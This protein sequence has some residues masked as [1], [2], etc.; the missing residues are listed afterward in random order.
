[1]VEI[2]TYSI[3]EIKH[4]IVG[5]IGCDYDE[6]KEDADID[7]DLGCTG[8]DFD[9]LISEFSVRFQV[10]MDNYLWYFHT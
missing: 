2:S 5:K 7:N 4:F 10:N 1:L 9:E 8:D 3:E 6:V